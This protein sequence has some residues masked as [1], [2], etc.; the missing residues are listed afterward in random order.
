MHYATL[1]FMYTAVKDFIRIHIGVSD[2]DVRM[3][4]RLGICKG[5][6]QQSLYRP[7]WFQEVKAPR[8][9]DNQH[10]KMVRLSALCTSHLYIPGN[11][12]GI[13]FC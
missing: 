8:F 9:Q 1:L 13:H 5:K 4:N 6:V 11:T 7:Q 10:M 12:P 3:D 2:M